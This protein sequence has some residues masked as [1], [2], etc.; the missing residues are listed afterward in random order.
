MIDAAQA[1]FD[2]GFEGDTPILCRADALLLR[3]LV[4]N[5]IDN[6]IKHA[7]GGN[8][9]TVRTRQSGAEA[10]LEVEDNGC[11]IPSDL[12]ATVSDRFVSGAS[13][14][15]AHSGLG[16]A[17]VNEIARLFGGDMTLTPGPSGTG[18]TVAVRLA[19]P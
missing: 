17:I 19:R 13:G 8:A 16:L 6:A 11:G 4:G 1:G 10:I 2:L 14:T 12:R 15:A 18:L 5:L 3:E 9:I 7:S